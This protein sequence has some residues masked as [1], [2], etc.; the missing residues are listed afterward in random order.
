VGGTSADI[1]VMDKRERRLLTL[2]DMKEVSAR[3]RSEGVRECKIA[4]EELQSTTQQIDGDYYF[5]GI[6]SKG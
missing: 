1:L 5:Q 6:V 2:V 3:R 4:K